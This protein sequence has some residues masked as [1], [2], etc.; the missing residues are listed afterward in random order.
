MNKLFL[1]L[2]FLTYPFIAYSQDWVLITELDGRKHYIDTGS[3]KESSGFKWAKHKS[4]YETV[5]KGE[6]YQNKKIYKYI[7]TNSLLALNCNSRTLNPIKTTY[8]DNNG[9]TVHEIA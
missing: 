3:I 2:I 7:Q 8:F 6:D 1:I 5:Q 4:Q 9:S